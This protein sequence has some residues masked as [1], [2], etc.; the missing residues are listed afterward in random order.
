MITAFLYGLQLG[1]V[2]L[3]A[4]ILPAAA[5]L[6]TLLVLAAYG[7]RVQAAKEA[8]YVAASLDFMSR[9]QAAAAE[10]KVT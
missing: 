4:S 3:G 8:K 7:R 9:L 6:G 1:A 10:P 5:L 2:L